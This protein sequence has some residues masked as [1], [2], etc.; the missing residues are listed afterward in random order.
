MEL[1]KEQIQKVERFVESKLDSLN[2]YHT[3][4]MRPIAK[5]LAGLEKADKGIV[6]V[7]I[8]F[9]DLGKIKGS[10]SHSQISA[11]IARKYLEKEGFEQS[12]VEEVV[13][14]VLVHSYPWK[15]KSSLIKTT[16]A[17]VLFDADMIQ[18]I[19]EFG[20]IK[21]VFIFENEFKENFREALILSRDTIFK[22]YNLILTVNGR[23]M[24]EPGYK[25]VKDFFKDLL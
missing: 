14:S 18:Q 12:F 13:Y 17:K 8:L 9:H 3:Q 24:A 7:S 15:D 2:W 20:I 5:K 4:A 21:Y 10:D 25:F 11:E 22:A 6:D 16:E 23:K 19:S 1:T